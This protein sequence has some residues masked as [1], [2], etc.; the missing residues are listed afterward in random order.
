LTASGGK[1][2]SLPLEGI[3]ILDL[4]TMTPGK[5]CTF[6]LADL[7]AEVIRVERPVPRANSIDDEDLI[8]NRNKRSLTLNLKEKQAKQIFLKLAQGADVILES[9]RPG[10]TARLGV[11]YESIREINPAIIYVSLSGFGQDGPYSQLPGFDM[12]FLA[13]GGLLG[14][15]GGKNNPPVVPGIWISDACSG[16][17]AVVG[18][19]TA[20]IARQN[21]GKGQYLDL[22]MLDSVLYLLAT[23]SGFRKSSGEFAQEDMMNNPVSPGYNIYETA[24]GK[25]LALGTFRPQSWRTL[26]QAL[27]R[28]DLIDQQ[29]AAGDKRVE[30]ISILQETFRTKNRDEWYQQLRDLDIEVAP[31]NSLREAFNNPQVLHRQMVMDAKHPIAG[32]IH[33]I[34]QPFK[35]SETP[36]QIK[37]PAPLIGQHTDAILMEI[38]YSE[39]E[40]REFRAAEVI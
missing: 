36:G 9:Q 29:W 19:L 16:L 15:L 5:Y 39:S 8:L 4:G 13:L 23:V 32:Q 12:I 11:D 14:L 24:D 22:A 28:S 17:L 21:K 30:T 18:I 7:G 38:G 40:I 1:P 27:D 10:S 34:G 37:R 25:Y 6:I 2:S 20:L 35:F 26:C 31:V 3:K 33:Q